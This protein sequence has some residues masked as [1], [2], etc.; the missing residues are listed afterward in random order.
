ML[1]QQLFFMAAI[2]NS[3]QGNNII[4]KVIKLASVGEASAQQQRSE[5]PT[6]WLPFPIAMGDVGRNFLWG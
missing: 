6:S 4:T 1:W 2:K 5:L 3:R